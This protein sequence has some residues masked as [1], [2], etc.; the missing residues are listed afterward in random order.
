[1]ELKLPSKTELKIGIFVAVGL[2]LSLFAIMTLDGGINSLMGSSKKVKVRFEEVSGLVPG[3]FVQ[4]NG[5][6]VGTVD[7]INFHNQNTESVVVVLDIENGYA[8][9]VKTDT[10][11][12][13]STLGVLGDKYIELSGGSKESPPVQEGRFI[14]ADSSGGLEKFM[15]GGDQVLNNLVRITSNLNRIL[16]NFDKKERSSRIAESLADS[17]EKMSKLL[18]SLEK[19]TNNFNEL[20]D[21][22]SEL[23]AFSK[24][25]NSTDGTIGL[26][27]NDTSLYR[28]IRK[29]VGGAEKS[30]LVKFLIDHSL[31]KEEDSEEE[32]TVGPAS[33]PS[34]R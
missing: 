33:V 3:A 19:N 8:D 2:A 27:V 1:M 16:E 17:S 6:R 4:F 7:D 13:M 30:G 32:K 15:S 9:L 22:I 26:L 18:T 34:S 5:I 29:L 20:G 25:L 12:S 23:N 14:Q 21:T 10:S 11:A 28:D 24:K 31:K